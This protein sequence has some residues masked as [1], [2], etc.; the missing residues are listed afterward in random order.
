MK[1]VTIALLVSMS[2]SVFSCSPVATKDVVSCVPLAVKP[3][4]L[5]SYIPSSI[6]TPDKYS[7]SIGEL[8]FVD[9]VPTPATTQK[10]YDY[11]DTMRGVDAFLKGIPAA[12]VRYLI[13]ANHEVG[14]LE[15]YQVLIMDR[16]MSSTP[17]FLTGNTT[18]LYALATFDLKR[19]GPTVVHVPAGMLGAINDGW[20][21]HLQD[22]GPAGPDKGHGGTYM[23]VPPG[24]TGDVPKGYHIIHSK[25]YTGW[26]FMRTSIAKGIAAAVKLVKD[27]LR[28][29]P[30]LK[31]DNPPKMAFISGTDA[32]INS[33]HPNDYTFYEHINDIIQNEPLAMLDPETRGL[34][35]SIGIQKGKPFKPTQRMKRIL[36]DAVKIANT[37]ARSI[38]WYPRVDDTMKGIQVYPDTQSSWNFA[39]LDKNVFFNGKDGLTSNSDAR[40]SF[41]YVYTGISPA[42]A[43]T[44]VGIGSDYAIAFLDADKKPFNGAQTYKIHL[45]ANPPAKDFWALTVYDNQTRSMLQTSQKFP[46]VGSQN[47][48]LEQN[49]DG[50]YDI[51]IGPKPPKGYENNWLESIPG[52]GWFVILR[53]YGPLEPWI[54]KSWRPSEVT[55]EVM[56]SRLNNRFPL[57]RLKSD[58][59][60]G[61]L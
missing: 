27:N 38:V 58:H 18:T 46:S 1:H 43:A 15:A 57:S 14:A 20:F 5:P 30:L 55:R 33:I 8:A 31:K 56:E 45:P 41:H 11:L 37:I 13:K 44:K 23:I 4:P 32:K 7:T 34:Y 12:S 26:I 40:T 52:K 16:L 22:V 49:S 61:A 36:S 50:S 59:G 25:T 29:Y 24:Y 53:I 2:V 51:Y 60:K 42:M 54:K 35:A 10:A 9:G 39:Y 19:D 48:G 3:K 47:E 17:L 21:R 28:I 6:L